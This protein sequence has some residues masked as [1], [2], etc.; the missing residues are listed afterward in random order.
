MTVTELTLRTVTRERDKVRKHRD[1]Y[2]AKFVEAMT[3]L[4]NIRRAETIEDAHKF[5]AE[6]ER[7]IIAL[8]R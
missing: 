4:T 1:I 8:G 6:A 7:T 3:A 5:A 2:H